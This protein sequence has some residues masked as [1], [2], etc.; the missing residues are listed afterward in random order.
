MHPAGGWF[1]RE[2]IE[3]NVPLL[4][5]RSIKGAEARMDR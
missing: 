3:Q 2:K 5:G 4:L 1:M